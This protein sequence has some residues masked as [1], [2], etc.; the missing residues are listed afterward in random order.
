MRSL[1]KDNTGVVGAITAVVAFLIAVIVG[2][3]IWYKI[4]TAMV[5]STYSTLPVSAKAAWN[6]TNATANS[7]WG[8]LPVVGLV[9]VAGVIIGTIMVFSRGNGQ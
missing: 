8:L 2:I 5:A 4:D 3:L 6:S 9:L 1:L 7:V